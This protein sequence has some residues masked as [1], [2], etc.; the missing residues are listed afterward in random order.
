MADIQTG[1]AYETQ[2]II[3]QNK[4]RVLLRETGKK[5]VPR[6]NKNI[7]LVFNTPKEAWGV[8]ICR[9]NALSFPMVSSPSKHGSCLVAK[10]KMQRTT[11][12]TET[13]STTQKHQQ[14]RTIRICP[15]TFPPALG[16]SGSSTLPQ[17][18]SAGLWA[19]QCASI[20]SSPR[21]LAPRCNFRSSKTGPLPTTPTK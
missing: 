21:L 6:Y 16:M 5:T 3:F 20:W 8:L 11:G 9:R 7:G 13:I 2:P 10:M 17:W 15:C 19:R 18:V 12:I 1:H 4:K 14:L